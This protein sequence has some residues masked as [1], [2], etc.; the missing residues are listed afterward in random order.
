MADDDSQDKKQSQ[1]ELNKEKTGYF[2]G[3]E[4]FLKM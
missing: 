1:L 4:I 2:S 3:K